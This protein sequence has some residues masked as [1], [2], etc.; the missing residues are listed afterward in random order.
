MG[1]DSVEL[2]L[3]WEESFGISISD[4]AARDMRTTN[5]AIAYIYQKLKDERPEDCGCLSLRAFYRLRGAFR[6][7]GNAEG[8]IAPDTK[9]SRLLPGKDRRDRLRE[10]L[11]QIGFP[12]PDRLPFGLQY[13]SV[14]VG[15]LVLDAVVK[16]HGR[17]R[18][19]GCGWSKQQVREV[20]RAVMAAQLNLRKF[21]DNARIV[22]DLGVD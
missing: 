6:K 13:T 8:P 19:P 3:G 18:K 11:H 9:V 4:A 5:D 7:M 12:P 1:L 21:S 10:M 22:K 16:N 17:L 14:S 20:A 15:E 2:I